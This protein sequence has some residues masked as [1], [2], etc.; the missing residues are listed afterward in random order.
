MMSSLIANKFY[1]ILLFI[2][3]FGS[4]NIDSGHNTQVTISLLKDSTK[5]KEYSNKCYCD[6]N[7]FIEIL[8]KYIEVSDTVCQC[9]FGFVTISQEIK[10]VNGTNVIKARNPLFKKQKILIENDSILVS[11]TFI[12]SG[13]CIQKK[14]ADNYFYIYGSYNIDPSHE[15]FG[16][17]SEEGE[18]KWYYYGD[19]HDIYEQLGDDKQYIKEYGE[20]AFKLNDMKRLSPTE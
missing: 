1:L 11:S 4:C 18:W 2:E 7:S 16:L 20:Q 12:Y 15:F 5:I 13:K 14:G 10:V 8:T 9:P 6:D 19:Q 17:L 3:V